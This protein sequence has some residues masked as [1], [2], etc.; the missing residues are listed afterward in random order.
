MAPGCELGLELRGGPSDLSNLKLVYNDLN[1]VVN[2]V[3]LT[4]IVEKRLFMVKG[5]QEYKVDVEFVLY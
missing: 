1:K 2:S 3:E 5:K 4:E